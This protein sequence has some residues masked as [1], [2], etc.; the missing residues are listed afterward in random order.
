MLDRTS[1]FSSRSPLN[2]SME[3]FHHNRCEMAY[4]S[5]LADLPWVFPL[6]EPS[7]L[8]EFLRSKLTP[9]GEKHNNPLENYHTT[10][11]EHITEYAEAI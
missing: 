9:P 11:Q 1:S 6:T 2:L 4:I 10:A 8:G 5:A 3:K 7:N